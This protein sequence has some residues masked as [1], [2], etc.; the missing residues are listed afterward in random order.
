VDALGSSESLVGVSEG[1]KGRFL[2]V[3]FREEGFSGVGSVVRVTIGGLAERSAP[4]RGSFPGFDFFFFFLVVTAR[5]AVMV[6][7]ALGHERKRD[8]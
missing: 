2:P 3:T 4:V 6:N 5:P 8:V 7:R 1:G